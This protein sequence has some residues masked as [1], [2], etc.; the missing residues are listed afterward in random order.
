MGGEGGETSV[1][2]SMT[3]VT[4]APLTYGCPTATAHRPHTV[5]V[6]ALARLAEKRQ[7]QDSAGLATR[8]L[9]CCLC[10]RRA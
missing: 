4:E 6:S 8:H 2:C 3:A 9:S 7:S 1:S 5:H 10:R